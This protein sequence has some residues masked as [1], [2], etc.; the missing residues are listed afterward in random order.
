VVVAGHDHF[1]Y[2]EL[3]GATQALLRGAGM[4]AA[5]RDPTFPM[6][7]GPWPG[8]GAVVAA[9]EHATGATAVVVGKPQPPLFETA[10]ER[11][12]E[13]RALVVGD[14]LDADLAGAAAARLDCAIVLTGAA[15]REEAEAAE[16]PRPVA[17][18]EDLATLLLGP[19]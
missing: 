15:T 17:V 14:R 1:D 8:T 12:G 11:L 18:A 13:G 6:P 3:R 10:L 19:A 2:V 16:D 7:D 4:V 5:G 9:L